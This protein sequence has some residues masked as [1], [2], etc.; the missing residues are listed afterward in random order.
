MTQTS[1]FVRLGEGEIWKNVAWKWRKCCGE[2]EG[3]GDR[4]P[5]CKYVSQ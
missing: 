2:V 3:D 5:I 4:N 1:W